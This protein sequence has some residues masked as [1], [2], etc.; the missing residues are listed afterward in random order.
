[1]ANRP[2]RRNNNQE[3]GYRSVKRIAD[4]K[5]I[6]IFVTGKGT[7]CNYFNS[8]IKK[9]RA[10]NIKKTIYIRCHAKDPKTAAEQVVREIDNQHL[11]GKFWL[12]FDIDPHGYLEK[13][14]RECCQI[15]RDNKINIAYSNKSFELWFI[16]HYCSEPSSNWNQQEYEKKLTEY[17]GRKYKKTDSNLF[18]DFYPYL[19][20]ASKNARKILD[21][22]SD[23]VAIYQR[24]PSTT[25]HCLVEQ[26][27]DQIKY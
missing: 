23:G 19:A 18:N 10:S 24:D 5:N 13:N 22:Y 20:Q 3:I 17:L 12:V 14:I 4:R 25:V 26:L 16:L 7:E 21:Q 6:Y 15:L 8:W 1:M 27:T 9:L 2:W 11:V